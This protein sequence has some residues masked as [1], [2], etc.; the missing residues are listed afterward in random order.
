PTSRSVSQAPT[1]YSVVRAVHCQL[2][3]VN[4]QVS[5]GLTLDVHGRLRARTARLRPGSWTIVL[6]KLAVVGCTAVVTGV[7]LSHR[8]VSGPLA[9]APPNTSRPCDV[10][11]IAW[12]DR[13]VAG[14]VPPSWVQVPL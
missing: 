4:S 5:P 8:S 10:A 11:V 6:A 14:A 7:P 1:A 2:P 13:G 3:F 9:S 12:P